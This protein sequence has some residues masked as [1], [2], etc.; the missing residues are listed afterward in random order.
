MATSL[1][2]LSDCYR[3]FPSQITDIDELNRYVRKV[4]TIHEHDDFRER[5]VLAACVKKMTVYQPKHAVSV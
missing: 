1:P 2:L 5:V 3:M 4:T